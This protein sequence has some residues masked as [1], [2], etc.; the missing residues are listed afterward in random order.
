MV[1]HDEKVTIVLHQEGDYAHYVAELVNDNTEP[2]KQE[3]I[4]NRDAIYRNS[5]NHTGKG[6]EGDYIRD[7]IKSATK[8]ASFIDMEENYL[9]TKYEYD[10]EYY[11]TKEQEDIVTETIDRVL[12]SLHLD[13]K[14][15]YKKIKAIYEFVTDNATYY[16]TES[17]FPDFIFSAYG[18]LCQGE[19]VCQGYTQLF[20]R[21]CNDNGIDCR[22]ITGDSYTFKQEYKHSWS[23]VK[24]GK[25]YYE[26]DPTWDSERVRAGRGMVYFMT[27]RHPTIHIADK[28]FKKK[29]FRKKYP[30]SAK[31]YKR[32]QYRLVVRNGNGSGFY[33]YNDIPYVEAI[34]MPGTTFVRWKGD[35]TFYASDGS[36]PSVG[37]VMDKDTEIEAE[38]EYEPYTKISGEKYIMI[39][40]DYISVKGN[41]KKAGA[42]LSLG[43]KKKSSVFQFIKSDGGYYIKNV[44]S[45]RYLS[46]SD[47]TLITSKKKNATLFTLVKSDNGYRII[48]EDKAVTADNPVK[49]VKDKN[50]KKQNIKL[51]KVS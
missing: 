37:I 21:L 32:T 28:V 2:V 23:I 20:Y 29:K 13:G 8:E 15:K 16:E 34:L 47:D 44:R 46:V 7:S 9:E 3:M 48:Y 38:Y 50:L 39:G 10:L 31:A 33:E 24:C 40:D 22:T 1:N 12:P 41:S 49:L 4:K 11:T 6:N 27:G 25:K 14:S 36:T 35:A 43:V 17:D 30:I 51:K 18:A 42:E 5:Y 26:C 45:K 19:A